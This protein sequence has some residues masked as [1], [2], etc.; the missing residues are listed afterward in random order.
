MRKVEN[1]DDG[2]DWEGMGLK[3]PKGKEVWKRRLIDTIDIE[4]V[5]EYT[6][7]LS[8]LKCTYM[9]SPCVVKGNYDEICIKINDLENAEYQEEDGE[10]RNRNP[11]LV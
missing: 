8:L 3:P 5:D 7:D 1:S 2:V 9:E 4:F 11:G 6:K 10:D